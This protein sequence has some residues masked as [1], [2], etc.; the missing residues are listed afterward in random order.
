MMN[1]ATSACLD[2]NMATFP[3]RW[4]DR[5]GQTRYGRAIAGV[6]DVTTQAPEAKRL[7]GNV[8]VDLLDAGILDTSSTNINGSASAPTQVVAS[9]A[10]ATKKL[11]LLDTTGAFIGVYTGAALSEV[12]QFVMGPGS[13]QTIEHSIPA[14]TR[15]SLKRL[16]S[17]TAVSSGIVAINFIG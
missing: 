8:K 7:H 16:D 15:I 10:A 1:G 3:L 6:I 11:Q 2:S 12:R 14:G 9:T 5:H 13:D 4:R 17:T